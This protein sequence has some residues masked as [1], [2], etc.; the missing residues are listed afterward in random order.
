MIIY[1][2]QKEIKII[3]EGGKILA[4]ILKEVSSKVKPGVGTKE[5]NDLAENL[6]KENGGTPAFKNYQSN[7]EDKPFPSTLC[8]S[9][10][11]EI[12]HAP[13]FPDRILKEGDIIGLDIGMEY[14][15]Y[16][17]DLAVTLGVGQISDNAKNIITISK[18]SL[19]KGIE[20]FKKGNTLADVAK[21]IQGFVEK[22]N[23]SVVREL[24][25][26]GV[27]RKV[28]EDPRVPNYVTEE[29][30]QIE[31]KPGL[32]IAIEPMIN[33]GNW[34]IK[35]LE[36]DFTFAT[37]DNSLSSQFEHTVAIDHEGK[38]RILTKI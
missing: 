38:T 5:L 34:K 12:V 19:N 18:E 30:K 2:T 25:G 3:A 8:T 36:D 22:N 28:H 16:Y 33:I 20:Q 17:T 27:G 37:A 29:A 9:I 1:K 15:G 11:N 23:Y 26:H 7:P 14:K 6:I 10:N 13:A 32:I 4:G 24:V 31:I 21:A 35:L